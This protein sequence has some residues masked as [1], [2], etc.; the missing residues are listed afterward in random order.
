MSSHVT[1]SLSGRV[2]VVTLDNPPVNALGSAIIDALSKAFADAAANG[3]ADAIVFRGAGKVFIAGADIHEFTSGNAID[4]TPLLTQLENSPKPVI[5]AMHGT[6][7]GGGVEIAMAC[8]YR[9]AEIG[10]AHV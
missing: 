3:S 1:V 5:A 2:A 9:L 4:M 10:R 6:A 8:H 7:L